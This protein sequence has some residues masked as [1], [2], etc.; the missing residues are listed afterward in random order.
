MLNH[1]LDVDPGEVVV[2]AYQKPKTSHFRFDQFYCFYL[3]TNCTTSGGE[4]RG[5]G[6]V[7]RGWR[8]GEG[9]MVGGAREMTENDRWERRGGGGEKE[10]VTGKGRGHR[11]RESRKGGGGEEV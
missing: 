8:E 6:E 10:G 1:L 5:D 4:G 3:A 7:C 11:W 9:G 2:L